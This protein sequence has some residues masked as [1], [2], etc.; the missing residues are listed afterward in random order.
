MIQH[1]YERARQASLLDDVIVATDD[2]RIRGAVGAFGGQTVMTSPHHTSGTDRIGE[3][4]KDVEVD[5]VVNIQGDEPLIDPSAI[6]AVVEPLLKDSSVSM[7][8]LMQ[9]LTDPKDHADPNLVKVVTDKAGFALYFSRSMIPY[10]RNRPDYHIYGHIGIYAY[11]KDFL[12]QYIKLEP[13]ILE[14]TESLEQL[15]VL[16]NG[17]CI[18]VV[19]VEH[20]QGVGVDTQEDLERARSLI[21]KNFS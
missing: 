19:E 20:Y 4:V 12:L 15:R 5:I 10:P 13:T 7:A 17:F 21:G 6:D 8:T 2:E 18:K 16:E 14:K 11:R 9:E 3:A 1:V